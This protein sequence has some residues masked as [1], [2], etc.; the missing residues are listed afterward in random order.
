[1][2]IHD[3]EGK[4]WDMESA[5]VAFQCES[6]GAEKGEYLPPGLHSTAATLTT[7]SGEPRGNSENEG[8][9]APVR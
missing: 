4:T 9:Q 6:A 1:M 2:V 5:V 7:A 8:L 3:P